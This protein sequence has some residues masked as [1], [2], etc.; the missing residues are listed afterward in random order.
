MHDHIRVA[1]GLLVGDRVALV[2]WRVDPLKLRRALAFWHA[3]VKIL[4]RFG[5]SLPPQR[6]RF[7]LVRTSVL[8]HTLSPEPRTRTVRSSG[9]TEPEL[10]RTVGSVLPV[11]VL[12]VSSELNF[13]NPIPTGVYC[14]STRLQVL[15]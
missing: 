4:A 10:N 5:M 14:L 13:G 3:L 11:L 7:E 6:V 2:T 9:R 8:L 15:D 1:C 12:C